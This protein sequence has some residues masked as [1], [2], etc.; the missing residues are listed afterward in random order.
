[1]ISDDLFKRSSY[2]NARNMP[3]S[4]QRRAR[5]HDTAYGARPHTWGRARMSSAQHSHRPGK[6]R[7]REWNVGWEHLKP[8]KPAQLSQFNAHD[9]H[10][11]NNPQDRQVSV[12][13]LR[14][15]LGFRV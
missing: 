3:E 14:F 2:Y 12:S 5:R 10:F 15:D 11:V 9:V 7:G 8:P 6:R 4:A 13:M 1:M